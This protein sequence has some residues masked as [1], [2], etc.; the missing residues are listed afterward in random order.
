MHLKDIFA[1]SEGVTILL[2]TL[3]PNLGT[4]ANNYVNMY[5]TLFFYTSLFFFSC[6][7]FNPSFAN[8][9]IF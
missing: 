3:I 7:D 8:I 5:V 4:A 1:S 9:T 6:V 2:S